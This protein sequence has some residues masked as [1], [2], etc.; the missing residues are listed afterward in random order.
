MTRGATHAHMYVPPSV[1]TT[2]GEGDL[3]RSRVKAIRL[4]LD[5]PVQHT[6]KHIGWPVGRLVGWSVGSLVH[7]GMLV[8]C[9]IGWVLFFRR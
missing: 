7:M 1:S 9:V 5:V 3:G 2:D 6:N 8:L 4:L